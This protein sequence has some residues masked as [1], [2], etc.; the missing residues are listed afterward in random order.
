MTACK[1][2]GLRHLPIDIH[3]NLRVITSDVAG[4]MH[5]DTGQARTFSLTYPMLW[6]GRDKGDLIA[7]GKLIEEG[8]NG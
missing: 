1:S 7:N 4:R 5:V 2:A 8:S 3:G 6:T